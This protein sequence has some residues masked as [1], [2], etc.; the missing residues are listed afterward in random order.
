ME[1]LKS[2][3]KITLASL[4]SFARRNKNS[5][6]Y[7]EKSSFDGMVDCVVSSKN[8]WQKTELN[9]E[10]TGYYQ[11]GIQGIYTVSQSGNIFT[12]YEDDNYFGIEVYNCCGCSILAVK[13]EDEFID[14]EKELLFDA[15]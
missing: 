1:K 5:L 3:K 6:F 7:K 4:K 9:T 8:E 13:K 14:F 2:T 11:T 15:K 10:K 12:M